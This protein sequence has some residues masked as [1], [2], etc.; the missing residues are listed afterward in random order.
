MTKA[1]R[2]WLDSW[3]HQPLSKP[4]ESSSSSEEQDGEMTILG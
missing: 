3:K 1:F 4:I 2:N